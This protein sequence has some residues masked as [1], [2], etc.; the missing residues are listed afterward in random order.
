MINQKKLLDALNLREDD[1]KRIDAILEAMISQDIKLL[2]FKNYEMQYD[3]EFKIFQAGSS[4]VNIQVFKEGREAIDF[5]LFN[6]EWEAQE[7]ASNSSEVEPEV[8]SENKEN[9]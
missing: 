8:K 5:C 1:S 4:E 9:T 7:I 2:R 3:P 6:D